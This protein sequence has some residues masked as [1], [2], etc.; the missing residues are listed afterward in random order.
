MRPRSLSLTLAALTTLVGAVWVLS[1]FFPVLSPRFALANRDI[2]LFHLPLRLSL[3]ELARLG[4]PTWNPWLHGGQPVLSNPNYAAFYPPTWICLVVSPAYSLSLLAIGHMALAFAGALRL[5]RRLGCAT[6]ASLL[7]A[8]GFSGCGALLSL[9]NSF[10]SFCGLAWLPWILYLALDL[11]PGRSPDPINAPAAG[12]GAA[13]PHRPWP[14]RA[15]YLGLA[16]GLQFLSG[17]PV[18]TLITGAALLAIVLVAV[19]RRPALLVPYLAAGALAA[20][21]AAVQLLPTLGRLADSPR[22]Q[23]VSAAQATFWS[24]PPAR[25]AEILFP[26]VFGDPA[27]IEEGLF[28]GWGVNDRDFPY[29]AS[30][31]PG[32]LLALLGIA[33]LL[34]WP[35][36]RRAEWGLMLAFALFLALGRHNP[37]YNGLR[38]ALPLLSMIRFPEKFAVLAV[39][40]LV[41]AGALGWNRLLDER[42]KGRPERADFPLALAGLVLATALTAALAL[43]LQPSLAFWYVRTH[44]APDLGAADQVRAAHFLVRESWIA[45]GAAAAVSG[46]LA[47]LRLPRFS[48]RS[49]EVLALVFTALDLWH[50]GHRIV[51]VIPAAAYRSPPAVARTLGPPRDR[52]YV[53]DAKPGEPDLY[54]RV[55]RSETGLVY[56]HLARLE[57]YSGL[58]WDL[59]YAF[60]QD[61]DL[62]LTR[63]A[64]R[65]LQVV[66]GHADNPD[67]GL[68]FIGAWNV[69][70]VVVR[71]PPAEWA[72]ELKADPNATPVAWVA[73][74]YRLERFRFVPIVA[75]HRSAV[76][77][78]AVARAQGYAFDRREHCVRPGA[79]PAVI[80]YPVPPKVRSIED[81][82]SRVRVRYAATKGACFVM[83]ATYD[84]GWRAVV[85]GAPTE[86]YPTAASQMAMLLPGGE[87]ELRLE[88]RDP[89]VGLGAIV[90]LATLFAA[91]AWAFAARRR[92]V[93]SG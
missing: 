79:P 10:T 58:L 36:P 52:I 40:T 82:A 32:L 6:S 35:I 9:L 75:F 26:R 51:K 39:A 71:K 34:R 38:E 67:L 69:G 25:V 63:W 7:A 55:A 33:A 70:A 14:L 86:I 80:G 93:P 66:I 92:A 16:V 2:S 8:L 64:R 31:Y 47:M 77:A 60:H 24:L 73:N 46:L 5:A 89:L 15:L 90:S 21:L 61:Y 53:Q 22:A 81:R 29:V 43:S 30:L 27:R 72:R 49:I 4:P 42:E 13:A 12:S 59:P 74:P 62:M 87:H 88:Y 37:A 56:A 84:K 19:R 91:V 11:S 65:A 20:L 57:P 54:R 83:A 76:T 45:V 68:R 28:F 41:F 23:G 44:G 17:E 3:S 18:F 1:F 78:L 48:R 50:Y 85:D